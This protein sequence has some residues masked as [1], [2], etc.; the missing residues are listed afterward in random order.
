MT[1]LNA[2]FLRERHPFHILL[3]GILPF[4]VRALPLILLVVACLYDC[5]TNNFFPT[6]FV[7]HVGF[8]IFI[9]LTLFFFKK[10]FLSYFNAGFVFI[11]FVDVTFF[12]TLFGSSS[13]L[14]FVITSII[15]NGC[16]F[17][18]VVAYR[19]FQESYRVFLQKVDNLFCVTSR[20]MQF[21]P[22]LTCSTETISISLETIV[23]GAVVASASVLLGY[24]LF[25]WLKGSGSTSPTVG[26]AQT[27]TTSSNTVN[28]I[29]PPSNNSESYFTDGTFCPD[30]AV[31]PAYGTPDAFLA[32]NSPVDL[33]LMEVTGD[34]PSTNSTWLWRKP[35]LRHEIELLR[36]ARE[37]VVFRS[38]NPNWVEDLQQ[39]LADGLLTQD[40]FEAEYIRTYFE[41]TSLRDIFESVD[42][43]FFILGFTLVSFVLL[44]LF[45][46]YKKS[47]IG[48]VPFFLVFCTRLMLWAILK[49]ANSDSVDSITI[50]PVLIKL[51]VLWFFVLVVYLFTFTHQVSSLIRCL[52]PF[53]AYNKTTGA[54]SYHDKRR[55][56]GFDVFHSREDLLNRERS[57]HAKDPI[58]L[59]KK[60]YQ[61]KWYEDGNVRLYEI[62]NP[63]LLYDF[64]T[65]VTIFDIFESFKKSR[66]E[67]AFDT[68]PGPKNPP[69]RNFQLK[70][71]SINSPDWFS[72]ADVKRRF[73]TLGYAEN[74]EVGD[75]LIFNCRPS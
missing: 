34:V 64:E 60:I 71:Q 51:A 41:N 45:F 29:V 24:W 49:L 67:L 72:W 68:I 2:I 38:S 62:Q 75:A 27:D 33:G 14:I 7:V 19:N 21:L 70:V 17:F 9:F 43:I 37:A 31:V 44:A 20:N 10:V 8:L 18:E 26:Q 63:D 61:S 32:P 57:F 52:P 16:T 73:I 46:W 53:I 30:S 1:K 55:Y 59:D 3:A 39:Q 11:I 42:E 13:M 12:F 6:E 66:A 35:E 25:K 56:A 58:L 65:V 5:S 48:F 36:P 47:W 54:P 4:F 22:L 69:W 28:S 23:M 74:P 40:E 50:M 15:N